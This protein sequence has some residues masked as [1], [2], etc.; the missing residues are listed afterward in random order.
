MPC[1]NC[2]NAGV[3]PCF[4]LRVRISQTGRPSRFPVEPSQVN[5]TSCQVASRE[6]SIKTD[7]GPGNKAEFNYD[8]LI[9]RILAQRSAVPPIPSYGAD[10]FGTSGEALRPA[11][12]YAYSD[13]PQYANVPPWSAGSTEDPVDYMMPSD[14]TYTVVGDQANQLVLYPWEERAREEPASTNISSAEPTLAS[15]VKSKAT[16][17][18][19]HGG[20]AN[21]VYRFAA[22]AADGSGTSRRTHSMNVGP[23]GNPVEIIEGQAGGKQSQ[24]LATIHTTDRHVHDASRFKQDAGHRSAA[25]R[26]AHVQVADPSSVASN[27]TCGV[28]ST[29]AGPGRLSGLGFAAHLADHICDNIKTEL[30]E[31]S[32]YVAASSTNDGI[33]SEQERGM[34]LQGPAPGLE[35][36]TYD[37]STVKASTFHGLRRQT[38]KSS[39][40][41]NLVKIRSYSPADGPMLSL[42]RS[43]LS[44]LAVPA[45]TFEQ[46]VKSET[47][48]NSGPVQS[49]AVGRR[50]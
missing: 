11:T 47:S 9:S 7:G 6:T 39:S 4:F 25:P 42:H 12:L 44:Q 49:H 26:S 50:V 31:T 41:E 28:F 36:Y 3:S 2:K 48:Y 5:T 22:S 17:G 34:G 38:R 1:T 30:R 13:R 19:L 20:T 29:T 21:L 43:S 35:G 32:A 23:S 40:A 24:P 15:R 8:P 27:P 10:S 45:T 16:I 46:G 18:A 33:F 14:S 37:S